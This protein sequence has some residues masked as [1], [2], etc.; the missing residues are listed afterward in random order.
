MERDELFQ[1][2]NKFVQGVV[3]NVSPLGKGNINYTYKVECESGEE[4]LLQ[5]LNA[6]ALPNIMAC[7]DNI[8]VITN[9]IKKKG[10]VSLT[11]VKTLDGKNCYIDKDGTLWRVYP[12]FSES[13]SVDETEDL[14]LIEEISRGFGKFDEMLVDLPVDLVKVSDD[15]FHNTRQKYELLMQ[16]ISKDSENRVVEGIEEVEKVYALIEK[17]TNVVGMNIFS[18]SDELFSGILKKQVVHNDTKLNNALITKGNKVLCV[19]DL[20]TAMPGTILNDFGD[21]VRFACNKASEEEENLKNVEFDINKFK[22]FTKGF[23][24]GYTSKLLKREKE[25]LPLAPISIAFELGCR[26]FADFLNGDIFFRVVSDKHDFNLIRARV[27]FKLC[28]SMLE[29]YE[30]ILAVINKY[31]SC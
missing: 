23:F 22:A 4:Y 12:F 24:S 3:K 21:G 25:L 17:C 28:E 18:L 20:D 2:F 15:N 8:E 16:S 26:F 1:V 10:E 13:R 27:Q 14:A 11:L 31:V 6:S 5:K 9:H 29:N 7:L 19:V 30:K